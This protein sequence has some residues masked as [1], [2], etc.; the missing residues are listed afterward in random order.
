MEEGRMPEGF[1]VFLQEFRD[2]KAQLAQLQAASRIP[3]AEGVGDLPMAPDSDQDEETDPSWADILRQKRR[4][5]TGE[6]AAKFAKLLE[7]APDLQAL[8]DSRGD[9]AL[10]CGVPEAPGPRR[11]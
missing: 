8:K 4:Q 11:N 6:D 9:V 3:V 10:Y 5:A 1:D 2:M 7:T